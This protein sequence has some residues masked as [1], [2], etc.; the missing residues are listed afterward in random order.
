MAL[1]TDVTGQGPADPLPR[2]WL[3]GLGLGAVAA[4]AVFLAAPGLDLWA[5]GLFAAPDSAGFPLAH[6]AVPLFF[7]E[8]IDRLAIICAAAYL[9]GL[10]VTALR[11]R[12][13]L[14]LSARAYAYLATSLLIG[15]GL[16]VNLL[17]KNNW[18]RARP[19]DIEIFGGAQDFSPPLLVADQCARNCSFT[20]GDAAMG[21]SL[22]ALALLA[23]VAR[24]GFVA[25]AVAFGVFIGL[26][27]MVQGAHFLSDVMFSGLIVASV[28][29]ALKFL[30]LDRVGDTSRIR[31]APTLDRAG[32]RH[33][34]EGQAARRAAFARLRHK[35]LF[36]LVF[37]SQR[38]D[39]DTPLASKD[40]QGR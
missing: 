31:F 39:F 32:L 24:A 11:G 22:L 27:R 29:L 1:E 23:P 9:I 34:P 38:D 18:G 14:G 8:V 28:T 10:G 40:R 25:A 6:A 33:G 12:A 7:N 37:R 2:R 30:W 4:A 5:A 21:F 36:W 26:I 19:R 3:A 16:I 17:L 20:S 35:G 15:P 13:L